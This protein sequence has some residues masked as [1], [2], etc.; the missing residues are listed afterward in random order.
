MQKAEIATY[1]NKGRDGVKS[2]RGRLRVAIGRSSRAARMQQGTLSRSDRDKFLCR[3]GPENT[4][5][6]AVVFS[7][8]E[9]KI[10]REKGYNLKNERELERGFFPRNLLL[11]GLSSWSSK[12]W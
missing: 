6:R 7:G 9:P 11:L 8:S 1:H 5:Y 2:R 4:T 10:E 12:P 3:N